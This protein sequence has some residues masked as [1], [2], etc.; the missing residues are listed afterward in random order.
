MLVCILLVTS[1]VHA[2]LRG[3]VSEP[4]GTAL[5]GVTIVSDADYLKSDPDGLFVISG[6]SKVIRFSKDGYRPVTKTLVELTRDSEVRLIRDARGLWKPPLCLAPRQDPTISGLH[7]RFLVPRGTQVRR[8][9]DVD[10]STNV[11][12]RGRQCLQHGWGPL[13]SFGLLPFTDEV[14][15]GLREIQERD[16]YNLQSP[17]LPGV[18]YRGVHGDGTYMRWVGFFGE[19]ISYDHASKESAQLFDALID[20]MC[21]IDGKP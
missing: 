5:A 12:C 1:T 9:S 8:G 6:K 14:L 7:L 17:E 15:A 2:Q 13:W 21:W 11:V 20:S 16:V 10:Y 19:T 3:R 4:A 18:D